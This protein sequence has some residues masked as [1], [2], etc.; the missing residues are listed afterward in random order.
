VL[1][2]RVVR[3]QLLVVLVVV[4]VLWRCALLL[5]QPV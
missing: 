5:R 4:G 3:P 2:Q 1:Q